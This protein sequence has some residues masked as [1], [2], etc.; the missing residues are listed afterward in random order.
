MANRSD[1]FKST[2]KEPK[3]PRYYKKMLALNDGTPEIRRMF[4]K[5]HLNHIAFKQKRDDKDA[6]DTSEAE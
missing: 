2:P 5:A 1:F 3:L 4:M 6:V